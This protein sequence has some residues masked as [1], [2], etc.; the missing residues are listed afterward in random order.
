MPLVA[1]APGR[2]ATVHDRFAGRSRRDLLRQIRAV[3]AVAPLLAGD[4]VVTVAIECPR[5]GSDDAASA[6]D[7]IHEKLRLAGIDLRV[8]EREGAPVRIALQ[9]R[10]R[11]GSPR[12]PSQRG[13]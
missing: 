11:S 9:L 4:R 13:T 6:F 5:L 7:E 3:V 1:S 8:E 2:G 10:P 12:P